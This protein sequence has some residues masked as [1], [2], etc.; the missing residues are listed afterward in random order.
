MA[1]TKQTSWGVALSGKSRATYPHRK[2]VHKQT[3]PK[4]RLGS[5]TDPRVPIAVWLA[6]ENVALRSKASNATPQGF[7]KPP[8]EPTKSGNKCSYGRRALNEI[9]FYQKNV[10]LLIRQLPFSRFVRELLFEEKSNIHIQALALH[11]LQWASEAYI[12]GLLEDTNLCAL[13][14]KRVTIMPKDIQLAR[15]IR[16]ERA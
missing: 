10:N 12:V 13:H 9:R 15:R 16:G 6:R 11:V 4:K 5:T 8:T 3:K 7:Y 14:T 2:E 1:H